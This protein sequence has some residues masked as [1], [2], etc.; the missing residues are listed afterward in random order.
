M[1]F[2]NNNPICLK[3]KSLFY[4]NLHNPAEKAFK[5]LPDSGSFICKKGINCNDL[6]KYIPVS[7]KRTQ[8]DKFRKK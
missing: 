1:N 3:D 8:E 4:F 6:I 7:W 2:N 5:R